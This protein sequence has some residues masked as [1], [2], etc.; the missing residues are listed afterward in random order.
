MTDLRD[1]DSDSHFYL[2][3]VS[4]KPVSLSVRSRRVNTVVPVFPV[5]LLSASSINWSC[6]LIRAYS[7]FAQ[8]GQ[9]PHMSPALWSDKY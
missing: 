7:A 4:Y 2:K 1:F 6:D 9:A 3:P 5:E 8:Q